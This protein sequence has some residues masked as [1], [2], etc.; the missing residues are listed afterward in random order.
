MRFYA[1]HNGRRINYV[2]GVLIGLDQFLGALIPGA[3]VDRTISHRIGVRRVKT[4]IRKGAVTREEVMR[5]EMF[6]PWVVLPAPV[7]RR[8]SEVRIPFWR[9]PLAATIDYF[10]EQVDRNHSLE[11]IGY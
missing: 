10:L 8:L 7:Q 11:S 3:E 4:A 9:H 2:L 5:G 6:R 1:M